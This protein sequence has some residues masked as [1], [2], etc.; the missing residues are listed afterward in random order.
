LK[1]KIQQISKLK[2]TSGLLGAEALAK[3]ASE[4]DI[5]RELGCLE[6]GEE[7]PCAVPKED[8]PVPSFSE[9]DAETG[10]SEAE[11]PPLERPLSEAVQDRTSIP[12][13]ADDGQ[14]TLGDLAVSNVSV[15]TERDVILPDSW[16]ELV[17]DSE[18]PDVSHMVLDAPNST[19]ACVQIAKH[20]EIAAEAIG[21]NNAHTVDTCVEPHVSVS[22]GIVENMLDTGEEAMHVLTS[23]A[24]NSR[25]HHSRFRKD[26]VNLN[27]A[28]PKWLKQE[29]CGTITRSMIIERI[30]RS[31]PAQHLKSASIG[32]Q[33][34]RFVHDILS[35]AHGQRCLHGAG[36]NQAVV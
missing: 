22:S 34:D 23:T 12:T 33:E 20:A 3:I 11:L 21:D 24:G 2:L 26:L 36:S 5:I 8:V 27:K 15:G 32:F 30:L 16:E 28:V 10:P 13:S 18:K 6:N 17:D 14:R 29:E 1:K 4:A 9:A 25:N 35:R 31:P 19:E 7:V